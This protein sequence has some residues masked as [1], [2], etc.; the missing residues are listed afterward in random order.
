MCDLRGDFEISAN[1]SMC[2]ILEV[3][4]VKQ[5]ISGL[6]LKASG[7]SSLEEGE[8]RIFKATNG[9]TGEFAISSRFPG[10][11]GVKYTADG[12]YLYPSKGF[13][14]IIK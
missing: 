4:G 1:D 5:D 7:L 11:W 8:H 3:Q 14:L 9:Y 10:G 12:A 2:G 13:V 6:T